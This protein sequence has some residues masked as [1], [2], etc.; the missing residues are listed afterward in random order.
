MHI[1]HLCV[2]VSVR[3][4]YK[5]GINR[6]LSADASI[7]LQMLADDVGMGSRAR[8][9]SVAVSNKYSSSMRRALRTLGEVRR[10]PFAA[11]QPPPPLSRLGF[12]C[13]LAG[14]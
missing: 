3:Q 12:G 13:W 11:D 8:T 1:T 9:P 6:N 7:G 4:A 5:A 14:V 2:H 10:P